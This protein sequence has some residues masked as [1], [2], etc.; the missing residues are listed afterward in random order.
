MISLQY[1][2]KSTGWEDPMEEGLWEDD[3]LD[4]KTTSGETASLLLNISGLR[5]QTED[6]DIWSRSG[7][8]VRAKCGLSHH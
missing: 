4:G 2:K 7:E 6:R 5:V 8:E 3:D 1:R